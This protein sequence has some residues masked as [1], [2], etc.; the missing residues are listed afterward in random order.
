MHP[1]KKK[2]TIWTGILALTLTLGGR[3]Q[4]F[5]GE[6]SVALDAETISKLSDKHVIKV[7][8]A[9]FHKPFTVDLGDATLATLRPGD[10]V[11]VHEEA[12]LVLEINQ[13]ALWTQFI[14]INRDDINHFTDRLSGTSKQN[15]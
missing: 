5:M 11:M 8:D 9:V 10:L 6:C 2:F 4:A 3:A 15:P 13:R 12:H 7:K 14:F 1:L